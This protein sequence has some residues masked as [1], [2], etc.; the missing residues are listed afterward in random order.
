MLAEDDPVKMQM[1][2]VDEQ[3][4]TTAR[5]FLGLTMGCARC[6]DHKF[7]PIPT[8]D[9]Y[10]MAGIFKSSK[11]MENFNVVAK[12][13]EYVL[14]PEEQR[15]QLAEHEA[16]IEAKSKA[17]GEIS[18]AENH[19]LVTAA[20]E[21][22]GDYLLAADAVL[23][24]R[25]IQLAPIGAQA[26]LRREAG[27]FDQGN[28]A[29]QV[30]SGEANT[31]ENAEGPFFAEYAVEVPAAGDYQLDFLN[32][33]TGKDTADIHING[34]LM[35]QG[36]EAVSN[37]AA[38]PDAGG[39]TVA[40]VFQ[41]SAGKNTIRLEHPSRFPYFEAF[42]VAPSRLPAGKA[43]ERVQIARRHDVKPGVL[44][45]WVERLE[46]SKGAPATVLY[47]W[48]AFNEGQS[49]EGWMSPAAQA[50]GAWPVSSR[51]E[52]AARYQSLFSQAAAA[53]RALHPEAG[54]DYAAERYKDGGEE[55][56]LPDEGLEVYRKLLYEKFGPFR[57]PPDSKQYYPA[58]AQARL[59]TLEL[60]RTELEAETPE[61]PRAMGVRGRSATSRST[62]A[63][64][65]GR[66]GTWR[67]AAS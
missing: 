49:L 60:E 52:L 31:P 39:W 8:A 58:E 16:K 28:V 41:L 51:E 23:R 30:R 46:R 14:A 59:K 65:T 40:G 25:A 33:E 12:W 64:A 66:L 2:I 27:S 44:E 56:S 26:S 5:A 63:A 53:W 1:D 38:S 36:A 67:R 29:R 35:M 24:D 37:R 6:H 62:C 10:A 20:W 54:I 11:T 47:A 42:G 55:P 18:K 15:R 34:V 9:Y 32:Q 50:F 19:R 13:H 21:K 4:D 45:Q 61:Y 17:M 3:L 7:D 57:P 22:T 48:H 43:A